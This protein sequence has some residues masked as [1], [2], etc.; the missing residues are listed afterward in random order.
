MCQK[1]T[2]RFFF[3]QCCRPI[4]VNSSPSS[5]VSDESAITHAWE[6]LSSAGARDRSLRRSQREPAGWKVLLS[7]SLCRYE[8]LRG[9]RAPLLGSGERRVGRGRAGWVTAV[10]VNAACGRLSGHI[11]VKWGKRLTKQRWDKAA[12]L[13][14]SCVLAFF[15]SICLWHLWL[16]QDPGA[17]SLGATHWCLYEH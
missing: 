12:A 9:F 13:S 6:W 15:V 14:S 2:E 16:Y 5:V 3:P 1:N 10:F 4:R 11:G 8:P 7:S 17:C